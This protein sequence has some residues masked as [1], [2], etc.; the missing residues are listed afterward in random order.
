M[1]SINCA[2]FKNVLSQPQPG[3][4]T[5]AHKALVKKKNYLCLVIFVSVIQA[6]LRW[7]WWE[8]CQYLPML[9]QFGSVCNQT[10]GFKCLQTAQMFV[11]TC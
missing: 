2:L 10:Q 8:L 1:P 5:L 9:W 11:F 4:L 7:Y 3:L 6:S